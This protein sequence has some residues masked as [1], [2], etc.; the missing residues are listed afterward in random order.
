MTEKVISAGDEVDSWCTSCQLML[1]HRV[2]ALVDGKPEKV[3]CKTCDRRHK[4]RPN[5]P[6]SR[7]KKAKTGSTSKKKT[8]KK[9]TTRTRRKAPETIWQE[10]LAEKDMSAAKAY[11]MAGQFQQDD[12]IDHTQFGYGLVKEVRAEGKMEV[13]FKEGTKLLVCDRAEY[14]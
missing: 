9:K 14:Q 11:S 6:K 12:I 5:P 8:T 7:T 10:A 3:I 13:V 2:V 4:Y 1:A